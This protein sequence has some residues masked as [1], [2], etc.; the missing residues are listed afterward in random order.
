MASDIERAASWC[1]NNGDGVGIWRRRAI[2]G[3]QQT[4]RRSMSRQARLKSRRRY[5]RRAQAIS[6]WRTQRHQQRGIARRQQKVAASALYQP[7]N[8]Q[9][10]RIAAG[11]SASSNVGIADIGIVDGGGGKQ[12]VCRVTATAWATI[13][14]GMLDGRNGIHL[15]TW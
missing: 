3:Q 11:A 5:R 10:A 9:A 15:T 14:S 4:W 6:G 1:G 8:G 12:A 7:T 2:V 13:L